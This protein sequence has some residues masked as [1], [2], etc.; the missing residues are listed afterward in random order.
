MV[1]EADWGLGFCSSFSRQLFSCNESGL[2]WPATPN[3]IEARKGPVLLRDQTPC[4]T[5]PLAKFNS[6]GLA[7]V[8]YQLVVFALPDLLEILQQERNLDRRQRRPAEQKGL[9]VPRRIVATGKVKPN[10][11]VSECHF[12]FADLYANVEKW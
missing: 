1:S 11:A 7:V 10:P 8:A 4:Q 6:E 3:P 9:L 5:Q 2:L 12:P